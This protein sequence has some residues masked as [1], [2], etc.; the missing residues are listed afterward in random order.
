MAVP[1]K[2]TSHAKTRQRAAHHGLKNL[3]L[4]NTNTSLP[5]YSHHMTSNGMYKGKILIAKLARKAL[6]KQEKNN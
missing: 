6:K 2:K 5:I 1:K 4:V 3:C